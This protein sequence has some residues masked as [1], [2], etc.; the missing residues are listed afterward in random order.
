MPSHTAATRQAVLS[1]VFYLVL[2]RMR[3]PLL[4]V[5]GVYTF[6]TAGLSMIP[7]TDANGDPTAPLTVFEAFY[8][9][10]YTSTTIGFGPKMGSISP[11]RRTVRKL[12]RPS[13]RF[14]RPLTPTS[15]A[16][17]GFG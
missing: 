2:R 16:S 1:D 8:V 3:F 4:L 7:G 14:S 12:A 13:I 5:I 6:C 11:L 9:V 10:S 15:F 17:F